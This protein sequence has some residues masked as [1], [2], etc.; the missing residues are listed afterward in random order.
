M[1]ITILGPS[2]PSRSPRLLRTA[3]ALLNAGHSVTVIN[4]VYE[5]RFIAEDNLLADAYAFAYKPLSLLDARGKI[6]LVPRLVRRAS[7]ALARFPIGGVL[8]S[9]NLYYKPSSFFSAIAASAPD[10]IFAHQQ[11]VFGLALAV[12]S[13]EGIPC[14]LDV[15]D[16]LSCEPGGIP[17]A[18]LFIESYCLRRASVVT[19]MS[20]AASDYLRVRYGLNAHPVVIYNTPIPASHVARGD[21]NDIPRPKQSRKTIYWMGKTIGPHSCAKQLLLACIALGMPFD[22]YLRGEALPSYTMILLEA[23]KAAGYSNNLHILPPLPSDLLIQEA[24]THDLMF[25]SQPPGNFFHELAIGNK[26]CL[27][28]AAG[29]A[30]LLQSTIAHRTLPED[31]SRAAVLADFSDP[32]SLQNALILLSDETYLAKLKKNSMA[33]ATGSLSWS[34]QMRTIQS[35]AVL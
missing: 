14:I 6:K 7:T 8:L 35:L 20:Q 15:E 34:R 29:N 12:A 3:V 21:V 27:G 13:A 22:I 2:Q 18:N 23:A 26:V 30:L 10:V 11:A 1:K 5:S 17:G 31:V 16:I 4:P 33:A 32:S 25:G 28:V 9:N 19:T 24:S